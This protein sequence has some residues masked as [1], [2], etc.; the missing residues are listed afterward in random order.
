MIELKTNIAL[1]VL[2]GVV[3]AMLFHTGTASLSN[4]S[5]VTVQAP[6]A[7]P[8][9]TARPATLTER[10]Q[11]TATD[12]VA[13]QQ[14]SMAPPH[15]KQKLSEA[16]PK[17]SLPTGRPATT[18]PAAQGLK[19][20]AGAS[21]AMSSARSLPSPSGTATPSPTTAAA[22]VRKHN[23]LRVFLG[24][25]GQAVLANVVP[26]GAAVSNTVR[27]MTPPVS[28]S[29]PGMSALPIP[30]PN[31]QSLPSSSVITP[32]AGATTLPVITPAVCKRG[33]LRRIF[34]VLGKAVRSDGALGQTT[35]HNTVQPIV[36]P[37]LP[38][39]PRCTSSEDQCREDA[40]LVRN[41]QAQPVK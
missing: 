27:A 30:S 12:D 22:P 17:R 5:K 34:G 28:S 15:S 38:P 16:S 19:M 6:S 10:T 24:R 35:V 36:I 14:P 20:Q 1:R 7:V 31:I 11:G 13:L 18:P 26:G 41:R 9:L 37:I 29:Y 4:R 21:K 33:K 39:S 32:A 23:K 3:A 25:L 40:T 2:A 8:M